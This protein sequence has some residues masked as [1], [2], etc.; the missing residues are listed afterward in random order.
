[1]ELKIIQALLVI[2]AIVVG[3]ILLRDYLR[4]RERDMPRR[5]KLLHYGIG[6]GVNFF[7]ALGIGSFAPTVALY[8]MFHLVEEKKIPGT[9]NAG[10]SIPVIFEALLF[11]TVVQVELTT[12]VPMVICGIAGAIVGTRI[13]NKVSVRTITLVLSVGLFIAAVLMLGSKFGILPA[14]GEVIGLTGISLVVACVANFILGITLCFGIGNYAPCM[15]IVY[16]LGMSPL[17]SFPLMMCS[18]ATVSPTTGM[19]NVREGNINRTAVMG[20]TVG[21]ILGVAIAV[22]IVKSMPISMLQWLVIAVVFYSS[23]SMFL[24]SQKM[25]I[26]TTAVVQNKE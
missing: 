15:C 14:G 16:L 12:L 9:M 23:V 3:V 25:A 10:V 19:M 4:N 26:R 20:M 5:D 13:A 1:M 6:F 18:G 22:Y 11:L 7:D 8:G 21:G 17:V 24:R 2:Y